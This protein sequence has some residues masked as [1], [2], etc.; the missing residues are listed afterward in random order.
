MNM[1]PASWIPALAARFRLLR[2]WRSAE[3]RVEEEFR[4]H[5]EMEAAQRERDGATKEDARRLALAT[6]GGVERHKEEMRDARGARWLG[7]LRQDVRFAMRTLARRPGFALMA[8]LTIAI[9]I[10]ATTTVFTLANAVL[11]RPL[12][13]PKSDRLVAITEHRGGAVSQGLEGT[14]LPYDRYVKYRDATSDIFSGLAAQ[15][16]T[17]LSLRALGNAV[18]VRGTLT[19]GNYFAVLGVRP[20]RGHF[21]TRDDDRQVVISYRFWRTQMAGDSSI[22]GRPVYLNGK[23]LTIAGVA[24][25]GFEGTSPGIG[26][27]I[28]VPVA[29]V[30][31]RAERKSMSAWL[32]PFGRLRAGVDIS[33]AA[34][35]VDEIARQIPPDEP[36]TRVRGATLE[37]MTGI[38]RGAIRRDAGTVLTLIFGTALLVLLIA[39]ANVAGMLLA[40]GVARRREVGTRL[41]IGAGRGR[42]VRQ[43]LAESALLGLGGGAIGVLLG[44]AGS[45][46]LAQMVS[47]PFTSDVALKLVPDMR[48]LGVA[49]LTTGLAVL[50]FGMF[51]ALQATRGSLLSALR[52][53]GG[54]A[55]GARARGRTV[56]MGGQLAL[57]VFLLVLGG[58][59]LRSLERTMGVELGYDPSRTI[60]A[61]V[62]PGQL[63]YDSDSGRAFYEQLVARLR[64]TPGVERVSLARSALLGGAPMGND[65]RTVDGDAETAAGSSREQRYEPGVPQNIV[66]TAFFS[67]MKLPFMAGRGF[68]ADDGPGAPPVVVVNETLA[69]LFWP[70]ENPVG[71][72]VKTYG[73]EAE[74]VGVVHDGRW[75]FAGWT[76]RAFAFF[77]LAQRYS[78]SMVV[79][80]RGTLAPDAL[81][82]QLRRIAGTL[83][84][85]VAV[86]SATPLATAVDAMLASLRGLTAL[87]AIFAAA[88]LLLAAI[89]VY[90]VLAFQVEQRT[91]EMGIRLALGASARKLA[92]HVVGRTGIVA[93]AGALIGLGAGV[94]ASVILSRMLYGIGR[95]DVVTFMLI[96]LLLTAVAIVACAGPVKRAV[97]VDAVEVLRAE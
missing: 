76:P 73:G 44:I 81:T 64:A 37:S 27:D 18:P 87:F 45:T 14:D 25:M 71:R 4:F 63:G 8:L 69:K 84:P 92:L 74:V 59:F 89:G 95:I 7:D 26:S 51:P 85:D 19:S 10:G 94:V 68:T 50:L 33:S 30:R 6:F 77:P 67:M 47:I 11:F 66:D 54:G 82:G 5:I 31:D 36:Q 70:G 49:L 9:G 1:D 3:A 86:Q 61:T 34:A 38:L 21:F 75:S 35:R 72:R 80:V 65:M 41:A 29:G 12:P 22:V 42:L 53:G 17:S 60:I 15:K 79:H 90:G 2:S 91:R 56:F 78:G 97:S 24:P 96:P 39:S 40:R 48:V 62:D 52:D 93:L 32:A 16:W 55:S 83:D 23:L 43:L 20:A 13:V 88:G 46:Q 28:W 57:A 58:L